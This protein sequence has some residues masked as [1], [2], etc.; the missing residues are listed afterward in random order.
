MER[1][2]PCVPHMFVQRVDALPEEILE[3]VLGALEPRL[4]ERRAPH[5]FQNFGLGTDAKPPGGHESRSKA[6]LRN[7]LQRHRR[8][9][10]A[11][12]ADSADFSSEPYDS[13]PRQMQLQWRVYARLYPDEV[14]ESEKLACMI[15]SLRPDS[16]PTDDKQQSS[17]ADGGASTLFGA[18]PS[19]TSLQR[20]LR[21]LMHRAQG[22][23][24]AVS[25]AASATDA[26]VSVMVATAP[27][28]AP[29]VAASVG[30][31]SSSS[32]SCR[33]AFG[34]S[35]TNT[36]ACRELWQ[37]HD[38]IL[39]KL[40]QSLDYWYE[41]HREQCRPLPQGRKARLLV[42]RGVDL[43]AEWK[44]SIRPGASAAVGHAKVGGGW[45][46]G[47]IRC[48]AAVARAGAGAL[49]LRRRPRLWDVVGA[50][51]LET[52]EM[53]SRQQQEDARQQE[54]AGSLKSRPRWGASVKSTGDWG[55][56]AAQAAAGRMNFALRKTTL[57]PPDWL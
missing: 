45:P 52:K 13:I 5:W 54:Q 41:L 22:P 56:V 42:V 8:K 34:S 55:L 7:L 4:E 48:C 19:V 43:P 39:H 20:T 31:A 37:R 18:L 50:A 38:P 35:L 16:W 46:G 12:D 21:N 23:A 32:S 57:I 9:E 26:D 51:G 27:R 29:A 1:D 33:P 36:C 47:L 15:K 25:T 3:G 44:G 49:G 14:A 30:F 40:N 6:D 11:A 53:H 28:R 10:L 24:E 17:G 2:V